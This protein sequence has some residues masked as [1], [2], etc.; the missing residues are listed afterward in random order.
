MSTESHN[1]LACFTDSTQSYSIRSTI[2][3]N[4]YL[5]IFSQRIIS[6]QYEHTHLAY[7]Y[8]I[9]DKQFFINNKQQI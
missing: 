7:R 3:Q 9:N 5:A 4:P 2:K 8:D 6:I 1:F